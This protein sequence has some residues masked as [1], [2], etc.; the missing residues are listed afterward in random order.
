M[1]AYLRLEFDTSTGSKKTATFSY[2]DKTKATASNV[3]AFANALIAASENGQAMD[4]GE[5]LTAL[6]KAEYYETT[7]SPIA[8]S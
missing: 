3:T 5:P 8:L 4:F 2:V 1:P 7:Y 6:L